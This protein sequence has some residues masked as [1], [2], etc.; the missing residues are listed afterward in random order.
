MKLTQLTDELMDTLQRDEAPDV[1]FLMTG[2]KLIKAES[3]FQVNTVPNRKSHIAQYQD[4]VIGH[5]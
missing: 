4:D 1:G 2:P 3:R 5:Y